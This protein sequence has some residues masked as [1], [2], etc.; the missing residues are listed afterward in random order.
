MPSRPASFAWLETAEI[1]YSTAH[2]RYIVRA[3]PQATFVLET[4]SI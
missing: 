4:Y 3:W 1:A 2:A